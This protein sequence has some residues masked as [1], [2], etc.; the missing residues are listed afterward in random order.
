[1]SCTSIIP[2]S[3]SSLLVTGSLMVYAFLCFVFKAPC[4]ISFRPA[5]FL[6]THATAS[7]WHIR[8]TLD[9]PVA[10]S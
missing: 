3:T 7:S 1:M 9:S 4:K 2:T 6:R 8:P 10:V 5:R